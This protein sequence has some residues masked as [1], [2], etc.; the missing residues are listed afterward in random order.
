MKGHERSLT[1]LK[2]NQE[3]DLLF[4]C[5]KDKSPCV[6]WSDNG[7]R[8]GTYEGHNGAVW[9][10]DVTRDSKYLSRA[11]LTRPCGSGT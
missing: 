8:I 4:T 9:S 1:F 5:A 7:E 3:G 11:R 10:L 6:W 2:Y